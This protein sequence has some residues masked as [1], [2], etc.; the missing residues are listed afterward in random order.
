MLGKS[1]LMKGDHIKFP[2]DF[3]SQGTI[4]LGRKPRGRASKKQ[5]EATGE[6]FYRVVDGVLLC[7]DEASREVQSQ[8]LSRKP[9]DH[10]DVSCEVQSDKTAPT[11]RELTLVKPRSRKDK[12]TA[13]STTQ[14]IVVGLLGREGADGK[15]TWDDGTDRSVATFLNT[16]VY[17]GR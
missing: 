3:N 2:G 12:E 6:W 10:Q 13:T 4:R 1:G 9:G 14:S 17:L 16:C 5:D 11:M 7:G 8:A 15:C